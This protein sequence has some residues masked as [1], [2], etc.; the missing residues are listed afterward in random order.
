MVCGLDVEDLKH[1]LQIAVYPL[2]SWYFDD[3]LCHKTLMEHFHLMSIEGLGLGDYETSVIAAGALFTYLRE[4]QKS[5]LEHMSTITPYVTDHY[6]LID[7]SSRR[8][9]ELVETLREKQ[10]RGSLL[11]VLDKTKTAMGARMM[12]SFVEQPLV[13]VKEIEIRQDAIEEL[14]NNPMARDEIREYLQPVYDLERLIS[15]ISYH[16]ANP[17]DLLAFRSS[18][19]MLPHI[20]RI[21]KDFS[22]Q[23]LAQILD[24]MDPLEDLCS[25]IEAAIVDDPPL[26]MKEGGII[27]DGYNTDVDNYRHA[28]TEGKTWLADLEATERDKTGIR[29]LKVKYNK[30]FGYYLEVTN[31]FKEMVPDYYT[32][33]QTLT[34]AERY[35]TPKLKELEDMIL[36]AEDKLFSLEYDLFCR[37]P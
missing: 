26:A 24:E 12:R 3:D 34:N 15:R 18:L 4:T 13:D 10:K 22:C 2:D 19:E 5:N 9:L 28:K 20:R 7:S 16:S 1:R 14:N 32:R 30:V 6:M 8:N 11:W 27:R 17:R 31:S 21:L 23:A 25:L 37:G 36:G 33:K 29:N 35:I